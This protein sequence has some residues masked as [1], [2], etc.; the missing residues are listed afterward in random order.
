MTGG[1]SGARTERGP[2]PGGWRRHG[3]PSLSHQIGLY[4]RVGFAKSFKKWGVLTV[5][6]K[7]TAIRTFLN[8]RYGTSNLDVAPLVIRY[9]AE[10]PNALND[11]T[12]VMLE[13]IAAAG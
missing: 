12:K 1:A 7:N 6:D 9:L 4:L 5:A 13:L 11:K 10:N 3:R 8:T 2:R